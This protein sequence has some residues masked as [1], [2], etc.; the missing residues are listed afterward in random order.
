MK[1]ARI[2]TNKNANS[3]E[4]I[5]KNIRGNSIKIR[6]TSC[7]NSLLT[8]LFL[9]LLSGI[10][11]ALPFCD[12]RLWIFAWFGFVPLFY[13]I[14]NKTPVKAFLLAYV[15]GII[16]WSIAVYWLIHVTLLGQI[17][18]ILYL[19]LYFG[20]FGLFFSAIRYPLS[21]SSG[22]AGA[23]RYR[24]SPP[25]FVPSL[26]VFLEYLR[27]HLLSGFGWAIL[28]YSQYLNLPVIQVA[29][30]FG[31]WGVSFLVMMI[32]VMLYSV[33]GNRLQVTSQKY[34]FFVLIFCILFT[35]G[36][37]YYNLYLRPATRSLKAIKI[38]LIQ[39]NIPQELKWAAQSQTLILDRYAQLS[40]KAALEKP[41]LIIWPEAASPGFLGNPEDKWIFQNIFTLTKKTGIP[42]LF[43]S[44]V[45]ENGKYFNSALL[46]DGKGAVLER[47]D[48]LHLVPFG[49]YIPLKN[50]FK[51]LETIVPI[52]DF[53]AGKEYSIFSLSAINHQLSAKFA[54]LIC[55]ED[56]IPE[57]S[58]N[59]VNKGA[60]FLVNITNDGWFGQTPM[61]Y[62]HLSA[63]VFRAIENRIPLVRCANTG[64][65][66]FI[67]SCGRLTAKLTEN[68]KDIFVPGIKSAA[69][70]PG[71][72]R[73]LYRG[74]GDVFMLGCLAVIVFY[75]IIT[76]FR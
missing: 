18:L 25:L 16:F 43:G 26:W 42:L 19:A 12:G 34:N 6:G 17:L 53:T 7:Q 55:F 64:V 36:Y 70:S 62:Q 73:S 23:I 44:V 9:S 46:V 69:I 37:G 57:L 72:S 2:P 41:D 68:G 24:L 66:C 10:I 59:F 5:T 3:H 21:P 74:I 15:T 47:Y 4:S 38:S 67:D 40:E 76:K 22:G 60:D 65:S 20:F 45:S 28:G 49:E 31:V 8:N 29:D 56:T 30:I 11:L 50:T 75:G 58:R 71:E 63:S 48:K 32:N 39:G 27:A 33:T 35:V 51:F 54:V 13:A 14:Q 1:G 52:G 61:P